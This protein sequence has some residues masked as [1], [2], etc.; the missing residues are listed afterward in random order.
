MKL[1]TD[2]IAPRAGAAVAVDAILC[3]SA[4]V[5]AASTLAAKSARVPE[6]FPQLPLTLASAAI[7][8]LVMAVM[9]A[10]VGLYR[11]GTI[12]LAATVGRITLAMGVGGYLTNLAMHAVGVPESVATL[13][14]TLFYLCIGI[15]LVRTGGNMM[16]RVSPLARVLIVGTG[17]EAYAIA[18]ELSSRGEMSRDVIGLYP[19][20]G[21][22]AP[23]LSGSGLHVFPENAS[24]PDLVSLHGI[25]EVIVAVREQRGGGV[26]MDQLLACRIKGVPVLDFAGFCEKTKRQV[27][28]D[29]LKGSWLVYGHG[30]VQGGIRRFVK[31]L[32]DIVSSIVLLVVL[33]PIMIA[34]MIAVPLDS[35]GPVFYRQRRTG[36]G[37]VEF[38]CLKFR[39]MFVDSEK[40]GV[41]RWAVRNDPRTTRV[42]SFIRKT[43]IDELP[44]LL[45][46]LKGEMSLV[47]P[48]PERPGF[49]AQLKDQIPFY[50]IRHSVKPGVTGWAQVRYHYGATFEDA[51][52]K[53]QFDLYYVKNNSLLL[54]LQILIETVSV[55]MFREGQ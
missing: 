14:L 2:T 20:S 11:P 39:S 6:L 46:V 36:L 17:P 22:A 10:L 49:V 33:S 12:S 19:S 27:P 38:T 9:Y 41:A 55:V 25:Q 45:S 13:I 34:T 5:L 32:F 42:G 18:R 30:F 26:P 53:H 24:I 51:R 47:G 48:R 35:R 21:L 7:F 37:G 44:Q 50:D 31:R 40:D 16:R 8:T 3:F 52:R 29:S 23:E 1:I 15:L 54:D 4:L 43:R 28:I